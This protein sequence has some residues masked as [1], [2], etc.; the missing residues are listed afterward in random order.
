[1]VRVAEEGAGRALHALETWFFGAEVLAH[2]L[3]PLRPALVVMLRRLRRVAARFAA[4]GRVAQDAIRLASGDVEDGH[5][6]AGVAD[7]VSALDAQMI[8][9]RED[10]GR[11][12]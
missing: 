10:E 8:Q 1:M 4:A 12:T 9:E 7:E 5:G 11:V 6:A 2:E 3:Q